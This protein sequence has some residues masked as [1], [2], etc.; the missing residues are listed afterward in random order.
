ML[1][2]EES[3]NNFH[4][5]EINDKKLFELDRR[6]R[7]TKIVATLGPASKDKIRELIIA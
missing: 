7:K 2:S 3:A 5:N 1:G 6:V 4:I